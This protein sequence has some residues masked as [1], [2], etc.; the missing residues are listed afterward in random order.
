M[1]VNGGEEMPWLNF[2]KWNRAAG[3]VFIAQRVYLQGYKWTPIVVL[4]FRHTG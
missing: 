4:R 3:K 1:R 2:G